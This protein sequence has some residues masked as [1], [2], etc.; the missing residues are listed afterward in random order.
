MAKAELARLKHGFLSSPEE[1][2]EEARNG[3]MVIL[4]VM[5]RLTSIA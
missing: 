3:R 4:V 5:V 2:I 1:L